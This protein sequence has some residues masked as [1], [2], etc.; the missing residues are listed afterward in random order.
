MIIGFI[1]APR[2]FKT[3]F[4]VF[5]AF[6]T[7]VEGADILS[8]VTLKPPFV[9]TKMTPYEMLKIP[10]TNMDREKKT[11]LI[12]EADKWFNAMRSMRNENVLL[13]SLTGQSGK[14]NLSIL[15]DTQFP[16]KV[17]NQLRD[18]TD[19]VYH[20]EVPY[21]DAKT[22]DPLAIQFTKED[23]LGNETRL[24]LIPETFFRPFYNMYD[25]YEPIVPMTSTKSM[26]ELDSM[27]NPDHEE[28]KR[29]RKKKEKF[30]S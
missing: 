1:G 3:C 14:R 7:F 19:M 22:K 11:L 17:D 26:N 12:Q 23:S 4:M 24:P 6:Q 10:F 13:G 28:P 5:H 2:T 25:S 30:F 18:V 20:C 9:Y 21:I 16:R 8:N 29:I 15:W 27:Y